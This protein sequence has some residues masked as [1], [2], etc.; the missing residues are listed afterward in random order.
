MK[1]IIFGIN[2]Q[3]GYFLKEILEKENISVIGVSRSEGNWVKGDVGN[4]KFVNELIKE[5]QPSFIFH[6]AANSTTRHDALFENH[7]T[8]C[9]GTLNILES[10]K[11]FSPLTKVFISGSGLQFKNTGKPISESEPFEA[12]DAYSISRIHSAYA[13]KYYRTLGLKVYVGYFFNHDSFL[14]TERHVNQKI[15][16][17]VKRIAKGSN[18]I[19]ELGD[20]TTKKEF[21]FAGDT[22]RAIWT[23]VNNNTVFEATI[24][25]G[26]V[27]SIE[28]W[29]SLCF[30]YFAL[31][32][33]KHVKTDPDFI[34]EYAILVSDPKTITDLGWKQTTSIEMLSKMMIE[35]N[36]K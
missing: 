4:Y 19:V 25:N 8:I 14:R 35:H 11:L 30:G 34:S 27:Y 12:R 28:D 10:V 13:A 9:T 2:G 36:G 7:E 1:A 6:L 17:A 32:W 16:A 21:A 31:D 20:I 26:K 23:L 22:V 3:D 15:V 24:G 33:K 29:L 5:H 18:E